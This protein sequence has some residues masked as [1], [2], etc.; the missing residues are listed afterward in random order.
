MGRNN[1]C[2]RSFYIGCGL[3]V[4]FEIKEK[5]QVQKRLESII[6]KEF[7]NLK[8]T[9]LDCEEFYNIIHCDKFTKLIKYENG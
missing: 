5:N 7:K 3:E 8:G 2:F 1:I 4:N 6:K 9:T